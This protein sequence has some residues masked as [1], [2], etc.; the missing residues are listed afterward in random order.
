MARNK[1][2]V[3]ETLEQKFDR[4]KAMRLFSYAMPYRKTLLGV[5]LIMLLSSVLGLLAPMCM[6][7]V[8]DEFI[9]N[10]DFTALLCVALL[11]IL[12][13]LLGAWITK[14]RTLTV[15]KVYA[16]LTVFVF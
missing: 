4:K 13:N 7:I 16:I 1:F 5:V 2:N 11:L 3:D 10:K 6:K 8:V 15:N 12:I 14:Y 9:P